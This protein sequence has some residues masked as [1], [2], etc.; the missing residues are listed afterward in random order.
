MKKDEEFEQAY[1][2]RNHLM[3][4]DW[5]L[6]NGQ[7]NMETIMQYLYDRNSVIIKDTSQVQLQETQSVTMK[8][9]QYNPIVERAFRPLPPFLAKKKSILNIRNTDEKCFGYCLC[10]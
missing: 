10:A 7:S 2:S 5:D 3:A 9:I 4:N 1:E 8:A 6:A